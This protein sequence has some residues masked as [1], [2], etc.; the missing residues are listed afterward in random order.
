MGKVASQV[1]QG[2]G[3]NVFER[4]IA[5]EL[6]RLEALVAVPEPSVALPLLR[7]LLQ[8][9]PAYLCYLQAE[10]QWQLYEERVRRLH[11][12]LFPYSDTPLQPLLQELDSYLLQ[13]ARFPQA[14]LHA[15]LEAAVKVRLNFLCRPRTT[16]KYFVFRG[17]PVKPLQEVWLRLDYFADYSYL[18]DAL[19]QLLPSA[20][21][22]ALLPVVEF[23]RLLQQADDVVLE[24]T[25]GQF[26]QL[27]TPLRQFFASTP[28]VPADAVPTAA[29]IILL[30]DKGIR[31]LA[32]QLE[33]LLQ[34][35]RVRFLSHDL[36]LR[37]VE[38]LL[39]ELE[40]A[41]PAAQPLPLE[42]SAGPP[43]GDPSGTAQAPPTAPAPS[44]NDPEMPPEPALLNT[45][46]ASTADTPS[47]P[48][49]AEPLYTAAA[50]PRSLAAASVLSTHEPEAVPDTALVASEDESAAASAL[51]PDAAEPTADAEY[52]DLL[53]LPS[54]PP[55][56]VLWSDGSVSP[57]MLQ[58]S[59]Q[60]EF[61][62]EEAAPPAAP[63]QPSIAP[64]QEGAPT[65]P[66]RVSSLRTAK[67]RERY[68]ALFGG[69]EA[70]E[71]FLNEL[72]D[73]PDWKAASAL[74]DR[75]LAR[76]GLDPLDTPAQRLRQHILQLYSLP[77]TNALR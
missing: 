61:L 29:L 15:L 69:K 42:F 26:W 73:C 64:A 40:P 45:G 71:Q 19:R 11:H 67:N 25:P 60:R 46:A 41:S 57:E 34:R 5:L 7:Q 22:T 37:L 49:A 21:P 2:S 13:H 55:Q 52:F 74:L 54:M 3:C 32:Q 63:P 9:E 20:E 59:W 30:D 47:A 56:E 44:S 28:D 66:E 12:P 18:T 14:E 75:W 38:Q 68:A 72:A 43:V 1:Q 65:A 16:L 58:A 50:P 35:N 48:D 76:L 53:L 10:A 70:Y 23:E 31:Y 36:F 33:E 62:P 8:H 27:I 51:A 6:Q 77:D 17:E 24:L 4:E 39:Q